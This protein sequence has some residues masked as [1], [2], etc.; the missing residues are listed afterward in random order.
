MFS[1]HYLEKELNHMPHTIGKH[2]HAYVNQLGHQ[3]GFLDNESGKFTAKTPG[4]YQFLI[5]WVDVNVGNIELFV[6][7]HSRGYFKK[8]TIHT[9]IITTVLEIE[10]GDRVSL[11]VDRCLKVKDIDQFGKCEQLLIKLSVFFLSNSNS[12]SSIN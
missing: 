1:S 9:I 6:N 4:V 7:G 2:S 10:Y 12:V 3:H 5:E 11:A 8:A